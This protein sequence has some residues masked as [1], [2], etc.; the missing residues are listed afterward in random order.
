MN[1]TEK[2]ALY[3]E[4]RRRLLEYSS[5]DIEAGIMKYC[6]SSMSLSAD[7]YDTPEAQKVASILENCAMPTDLESVVEFFE[8]LLDDENKGENGIV[9]TP[10]YIA[11]F[12]VSTTFKK[13]V[14]WEPSISVIDPGCGGGIFLISAAEYLHNKF[15]VE[16]DLIIKNNLFGIDIDS[17]NVRRC[18]LAMK[19]LCAKYGGN[20]SSI[21]ANILCLDSLKCDWRTTFSV[22][23][24]NY[25]IGNPPYVNPHDMNSETTKFLKKTFSTTQNGV[26][27]IFYAFIE[28]AISFLSPTGMLGYIVPN[29][30]LT[31]KSASDLRE[32]LQEE[33]HLCQI[34]DFGDNMVFRPVRTYNCVLIL[35]KCVNENFE[36]CILEKCDDIEK[37]LSQLQFYSMPTKVLDKHGWKL[38]DKLTRINLK[39]IEAQSI[40][41]KDFIRTGIATLRDGVYL[42]DCDSTGYYKTI[43]RE[44]HY[45]E[46]G[47]VKP[48][49]K[50]PDLK[51]HDNIC[52]AKRYIIFPYVKSKKGYVL[53]SETE[54][55]EKYP[56][57]YRVLI[58]NKE[59][60]D[61]RDKGKGNN[62]GWYAYGRTQGLNKY[63]RKLLFPTFSN[64]PK[65]MY[66]DN[67]D[68][69]FCNGYAVF[70]N[71]RI[72]LEVLARILNSKVMAYYVSNTSYSIE[73][74]YY[75]Y[76]KKY[77]E[78][79]SIPFLS[80]ADVSFIQQ[81]TT[82]ELDNFLW[83][84]YGLD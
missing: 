26:F 60:L 35:S 70:E 34:L 63:G 44:K 41:I 67:E 40:S 43:D 52:D 75:C 17:D 81:A 62:Q 46:A 49:Y 76:Q 19:L 80:E 1:R 14:D 78:R 65:F 24:F 4:L 9:F 66:V 73:G 2:F 33:K 64:R 27:N 6:L 59:E 11:D 45:I 15:H 23:S 28:H 7:E 53:I 54:L 21:D 58:L 29:N 72:D 77:I 32:Y 55:Q 22:S 39:R 74:G 20:F 31:I 47:L 84:T 71:D 79:F 12:I 56:F 30:F 37:G 8:F 16:I 61:S 57:T 25:I 38:V 3:I 83:K 48:I 10:K 51:L 68:D 42:V 13:Q 5:A 82:D 50:I 18:R 36:Y 69:L